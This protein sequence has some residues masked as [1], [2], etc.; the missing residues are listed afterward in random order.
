LSTTSTMPWFSS[1]TSTWRWPL[2]SALWMS[3]PPPPPITSARPGP[4]IA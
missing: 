1:I 2:D 3:R 4:V